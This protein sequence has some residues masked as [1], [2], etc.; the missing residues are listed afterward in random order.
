MTTQADYETLKKAINSGVKTVRYSDK[1]VEYRTLS[2]MN[3]IKKDMENEL[4][5]GKTG[6]ATI[7][8]FSR[9]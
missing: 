3:S 5:I 8:S 7:A 6:R 2:E 9:D 1:T 4:G